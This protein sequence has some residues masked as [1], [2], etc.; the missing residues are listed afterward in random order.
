MRAVN[1][2]VPQLRWEPC[3]D[4][5]VCLECIATVALPFCRRDQSVADTHTELLGAIVVPLAGCPT[6]CGGQLAMPTLANSVRSRTYSSHK[7]IAVCRL[8]QAQFADRRLAV[9]RTLHIPETATGKRA[10][11]LVKA[12]GESGTAGSLVK[13]IREQRSKSTRT[14][15]NLWTV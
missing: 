11:S 4:R 13:A 3:D 10:G 2:E 6:Y 15:T 1:V 14:A 9:S 12:K 7:R 8:S 5:S